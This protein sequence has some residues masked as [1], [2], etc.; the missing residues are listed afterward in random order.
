MGKNERN[1]GASFRW[2]LRRG[3]RTGRPAQQSNNSAAKG[4]A[5][6]PDDGFFIGVPV[7][8]G[9]GSRQDARCPDWT[10]YPESE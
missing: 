1:K 10:Y 6:P 2:S 4:T 5:K 7:W 3:R 9:A 8:R